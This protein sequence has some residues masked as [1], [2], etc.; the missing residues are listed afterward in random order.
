M[1]HLYI[2]CGNGA[3]GPQAVALIGRVGLHRL[4]HEVAIVPLPAA[5]LEA[6]MWNPRV[7]ESL[8]EALLET[9][10]EGEMAAVV[11]ISEMR[12]I[13]DLL[14]TLLTDHAHQ[15]RGSD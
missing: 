15:R 8:P 9:I 6:L 13:N 14:T 3:L 4:Y 12:E 2:N 10:V 7:G 5:E 1:Y 11:Q